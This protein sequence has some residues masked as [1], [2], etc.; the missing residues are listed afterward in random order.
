MRSDVERKP[1][2]MPEGLGAGGGGSST[3]CCAEGGARRSSRLKR[4]SG[5]LPPLLGLFLL[6]GA[7]Y[8]VH[9]E[10]RH[11]SPARIRVT[12]GE[13][14]AH[15]LLLS[16]GFTVLSYFI[17]S[18][19]DRLAVAHVG[20]RLSFGRTAFAAFCSYVL[21]HNLGFAAISGA[22][23]RFRLYGSWGLKPLEITRIIAF[24]SI[25][26][27]LG[28][29]ALIGG[30]LLLEPSALSALNAH[31]PRGLMAVVGVAAWAVVLAYIV[32]SA[33]LPSVRL[34][35]W[36]VPLPG[37]QMAIAQVVVSALD[38]A[39]TAAIAYA[40]LPAG[41]GLSYPA[42]LAIYIACYSAGLL[43]S[44]PGGLGVFDGAMVLGLSPF[45]PAA[46]AVAAILVFRLYYYILP[47]FLAGLLF[48]GH[49]LFLRG[50]SLLAARAGVE[51]AAPP[52]PSLAVRES[53]ADFSVTVATGAV[54]LCGAMLIATGL[55]HR[56]PDDLA[57]LI[58]ALGPA[59]PDGLFGGDAVGGFTRGIEAIGDYVLSLIGAV[60]IGLAI[61]LSQRVTLA[62]GATL[63]FLSIAAALSALRGLPLEVPAVLIL[64]A[65]AIAPFRSSYYRHARV[66][67]EPLA[68]ATM[69]PLL[70]L[71]LSL[72][73]LS[74]LEPGGGVA[75]ARGWLPLVLGAHVPTHQRV[76]TALAVLV[77]LVALGRLVRPGHV[78]ALPFSGEPA[79]RWSQF[80]S[81]EGLGI[82]AHGADGLMAG[83]TGRALVAF[84]R[85]RGLL[86]GLG[87]PLGA[88]ADRVSAI[89]R[90]RD[91]A[92]EEQRAPVF[93][94]VG[95]EL[96]PVY[97]DL[98]LVSWPL[99]ETNTLFLCCA[100]E[101]GEQLLARLETVSQG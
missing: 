85:E 44:V 1:V 100:A 74:R 87:D 81:G 83:E 52:R 101:R 92:L 79:T 70:L 21:S 57:L 45:M 40:L 88:A 54:I 46:D 33:R 17:L 38:V 97:A 18:F 7:I 91:L 12:L 31:L 77:G 14:P 69:A 50:D 16:A 9:N 90:L 98:G 63:V 99:D 94:R 36:T 41:I 27:L 5:L 4:L 11:L 35:R 72:L 2:A 89:W 62:W 3:P 26:Y 51:R 71:V 28:A 67:S 76:S 84:R 48:A 24:C 55:F 42:F 53:E 13:I 78:S 64:A 80:A 32:L 49:E 15:A 30:V 96:L 60:L 68:P 29:C 8:A 56:A 23:V 66:L 37:V 61:G 82:D 6:V 93:W 22:A 39:A 10:F 58:P 19:Y 73:I 86:I 34:W 43:A 20:R 25:T 75:G 47:L 65:L 59:G 95:P